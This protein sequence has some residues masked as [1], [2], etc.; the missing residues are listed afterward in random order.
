[1]R[2]TMKTNYGAVG[3]WPPQWFGGAHPRKIAFKYHCLPLTI[4]MAPR[5]EIPEVP[6]SSPD[7]ES[8]FIT[9]LQGGPEGSPGVTV[10]TR[11]F[12]PPPEPQGYMEEEPCEGE[13]LVLSHVKEDAEEVGDTNSVCSAVECK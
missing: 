6:Q 11:Q 9:A 1:M 13:I 12:N 2:N 8:S 5:P 3:V 10:P 7:G 4:K